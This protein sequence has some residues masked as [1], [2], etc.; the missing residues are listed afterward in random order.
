M[1]R[2]GLRRI[3]EL[4][5][6][7]SGKTRL[8]AAVIQ[9]WVDDSDVTL[10]KIFEE[11]RGDRIEYHKKQRNKVTRNYYYLIRNGVAFLYETI[12]KDDKI[13]RVDLYLVG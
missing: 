2:R 4:D 12:R 1:K 11:R 13:P 8:V 5:D 7:L 9:N 6:K 10:R 3:S